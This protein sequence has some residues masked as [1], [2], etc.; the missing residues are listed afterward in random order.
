[1]KKPVLVALSGVLL[2]ASCGSGPA[3]QP[4]QQEADAT[5]A[6]DVTRAARTFGMTRM[7][8]ASLGLLSIEAAA[9]APKEPL[10]VTVSVKEGKTGTKN[11]GL[12]RAYVSWKVAG[13]GQSA[14]T[15]TLNLHGK[16]GDVLKTK[17]GDVAV[18]LPTPA[19]KDSTTRSR[20]SAYTAT[21]GPA[22]AS[23][24]WTWT[25]TPAQAPAP[26]SV[27][28]VGAALTPQSSSPTG[29]AAAAQAYLQPYAD[30][31]NLPSDA[32]FAWNWVT[33]P[34]LESVDGWSVEDI[35][36]YV[37]KHIADGQ[38]EDWRDAMKEVF[39]PEI[40]VYTTEEPCH[41]CHTFPVKILAPAPWGGYA[42][43]E[44]SV[45]WDS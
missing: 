29:S 32:P 40:K 27:C 26:L 15:Y 13:A 42:G 38:F 12:K 6:D 3:V 35:D 17:A 36:T 5:D 37:E 30:A 28:E 43:F 4:Q 10:T 14:G 31:A 7:Q 33:A 1:M 23:L 44:A 24:A 16:T 22:C 39:G 2:L 45:F 41:N 25:P 18:S 34:D 9:T 21:N 8:A 11:A 19:G 20:S